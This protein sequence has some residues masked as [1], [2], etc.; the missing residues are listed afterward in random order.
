MI[1][2]FGASGKTGSATVDAL[3]ARGA[4]FRAVY[5]DPAKLA[6][7]RRR[8]V[9]AVSADYRDSGSLDA[10]L[11]GAERVFL[12]APPVPDLAE[13]EGA[14]VAAALRAGV[15]NVVKVSAW[16]VPRG[17]YQFTA[18]H[19]VSEARIVRS[20]MDWTFLRPNGFMQQ[21]LA[22]AAMIRDT[23]TWVF[24]LAGA[25]SVIDT[26][27]V[28]RVAAHCLTGSGHEGQAYELSGPEGLTQDGQMAILSEA[29][30]REIRYV[31]PPDEE[32]RAGALA[33]GLPEW[34]VDRLIDL[35]RYFRNGEG[36]RVTGEVERLTG[37]PPTPFHRFAEDYAAAFR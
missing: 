34:L 17:R 20:G 18:P 5:R 33:A 21:L 35:Q 14:A 26:R 1:L 25:V 31:A 8:G 6:A 4:A 27:D 24:P 11:A 32:W 2:V 9:E 29:V 28:G 22:S 15:R 37:S 12:V 7:A 16:D 30:G 3:Q 23:G 19:Q 13:M 36:A 10:A